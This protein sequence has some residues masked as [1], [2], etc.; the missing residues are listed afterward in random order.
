MDQGQARG[1][2][3]SSFAQDDPQVVKA[4]QVGPAPDQNQ[5]G[6]QRQRSDGVADKRERVGHPYL[7][8]EGQRGKLCQ[9]QRN[10]PP[11]RVAEA[12]QWS[13]ILLALF[14]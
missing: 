10:V 11:F 14:P 3:H 2:Q 6:E 8:E 1:A 7:D 5:Q 9:D 13:L 4:A 12:A